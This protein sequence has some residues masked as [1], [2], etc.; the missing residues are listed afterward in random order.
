M[1][2]KKKSTNFANKSIKLALNRINKTRMITQNDI[3]TQVVNINPIKVE[4][5][6]LNDDMNMEKSNLLYT[7]NKKTSKKN[8]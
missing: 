7:N 2:L 5:I 4:L 1:F 8:K 3:E 6:T